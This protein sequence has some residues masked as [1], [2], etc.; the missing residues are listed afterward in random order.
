M[1][2]EKRFVIVVIGNGNMREVSI[3]DTDEGN[4][5]LFYCEC[6]EENLFFIKQ[7]VQQVLD[8]LNY[9]NDLTDELI[10][11]KKKL[12]IRWADQIDEISE[13]LIQQYNLAEKDDDYELMKKFDE[14]IDEF[15]TIDS[16]YIKN[17]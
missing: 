9:Q 10:E 5:Q 16:R 14:L 3:N 17:R 6:E 7:E 12:K 1:D 4:A 13:L 15:E 2:D 8:Q 11:D